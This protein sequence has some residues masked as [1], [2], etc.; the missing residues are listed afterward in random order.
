MDDL[1]NKL[2]AENPGFDSLVLQ[3]TALVLTSPPSFIYINDPATPRISSSV[4]T[5]VLSTISDLSTEPLEPNHRIHCA[6][7]NAVACFTPRLLYDSILNGLANWQANWTDGCENWAPSD[8]SPA[9]NENLNSFVHGLKALHA[10]LASSTG[11]NGKSNGKAPAQTVRLV[12][13][14][15]RAERLKETMLDLIGPLTRLAELVRLSLPKHRSPM[16]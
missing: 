3:T 2:S 1:V 12:I 8:E 14:I 5:A 9:W 6:S 7:V 4:I 13:M 10:E 11:R 16:F 15:E